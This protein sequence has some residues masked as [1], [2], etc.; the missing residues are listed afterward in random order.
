MAG[1][2]STLRQHLEPLKAPK[3]LVAD[4]DADLAFHRA[5]CALSGNMVLLQNWESISSLMRITMHA[6]GAD[7]ARDNMA[8]ERHA[9]IVDHIESADESG[10]RDFLIEHMHSARDRLVDRMLA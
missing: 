6:A 7:P 10:A 3:D 9:P 2:L 1:H 5:V 4:L 8:Y